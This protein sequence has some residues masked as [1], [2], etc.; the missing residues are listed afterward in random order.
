MAQASDHSIHL[1]F[2]GPIT[3]LAHMARLASATVADMLDEIREGR[4]YERG[5]RAREVRGFPPRRNG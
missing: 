1:K 2:D 3:D 5:R 4:S